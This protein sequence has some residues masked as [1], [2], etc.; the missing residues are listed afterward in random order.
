[1]NDV[2]YKNSNFTFKSQYQIIN[3]GY[4]FIEY[5]YHSYSGTDKEKY[6]NPYFLAGNQ[7][8]SLGMNFGF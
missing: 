3:D 6:T 4:V 7:I 5:Q 2:R 1:M 8:V